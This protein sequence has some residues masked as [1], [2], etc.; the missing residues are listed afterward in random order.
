MKLNAIEF[1]LMNNPV[2][3]SIQRRFESARLLRMGGGMNGGVALEIGCGRG[4]GLE[5]ILD[6]F[7]AEFVDGF[8]LDVR[9]VVLAA[10]RMQRRGPIRLWVGDCTAIP[11]GDAVYDAVFDF[12]ILHHVPDWR[13]ALVEIAR[14]LRPGGR[15]YAEEALGRFITHPATKLMLSHPQAD[16]FEATEFELAMERCGFAVEATNALGCA[17]AWFVGTKTLSPRA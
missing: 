6:Q 4:V 11:V 8:D 3:A 13:G 1:A 10:R 2:R 16:R 17:L 12:G 7:G 14:V 5:I 15:F 9:M